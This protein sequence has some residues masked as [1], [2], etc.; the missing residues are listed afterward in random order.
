M[1]E[2]QDLPAG[3]DP[4]IEGPD[5][6]V[7]WHAFTQMADYQP[8][9]I[10]QADGCELIDTDGNRYLDAVSSLWCNIH[11]HNHPTINAAIIG[12][13]QRVSHVTSLGMSNPTTV[14]L[15]ARLVKLAPDGLEHVFFSGDGASSV[16]VALK[17]AFQYWRQCDDPQPEKSLF[18]ALGRAYHGDTLGSVSVGGVAR[19]HQMFEPLLFEAIHTAIPDRS[20]P[21]EGVRE[22]DACEH[23]LGE[24][25]RILED[26]H[27]QT[28]AVIIEP[29][30]QGAAGMV[31]HPDGYLAGVR[32]L[33]RAYN[34]LMI[35]DEVAVGFGRTGTMFACQQEEV[36]PDLL[37]L[38]KGL[39]GGY[40]AM[41]VTLARTE[42]F[43]AFLGDPSRTFFHGHTY[44]GNP[45]AAAAALASL[46]I[47]EQ[48]QTLQHLP[49]TI[50]HL[51]RCLH[52]LRDHPLVAD[53]RQRGMIAAVELVEETAD[54]RPL[55]AQGQSG[56]IVCQHALQ[57]G[58][59]FR[60]L[61]DI[62]VI[63]PPLSVSCEQV[64]RIVDALAAGID[65]L[66]SQ[67]QHAPCQEN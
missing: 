16:E 58:V 37:C 64:S 63:M 14:E 44:G 41:A 9:I 18:I 33:T 5:H 7:V 1:T 36:S 32:R 31:M 45:L 35:A 62:L 28:A 42:I 34:V 65:Q 57:Q 15:A 6:S 10:E 8:F 20:R 51:E 43:N 49:A 53:V 55:P 12:Q 3:D 22:E 4:R 2:N 11:G 27:R 29:L 47:F 26:H 50:E 60:P 39:T 67:L 66:A 40:L 23:Y 56:A 46:D 19:F 59:W 52:P 48:E 54:G 38:A 61:R 17:M 13:L 30:V 21:P 24:L 25:E